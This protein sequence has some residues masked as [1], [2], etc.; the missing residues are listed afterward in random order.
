MQHTRLML[1]LSLSLSLPPP[2]LEACVLAANVVKDL[3]AH[4]EVLV[5]GFN[6][7]DLRFEQKV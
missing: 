5:Q 4:R 2:V 1:C 3:L 6:E 7:L